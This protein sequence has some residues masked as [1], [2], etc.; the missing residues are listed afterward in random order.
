MTQHY[1]VILVTCCLQQTGAGICLWHK[2]RCGTPLVRPRAPSVHLLYSEPNGNISRGIV[3]RDTWSPRAA[4]MWWLSQAKCKRARHS[5]YMC[6]CGNQLQLFKKWDHLCK[7]VGHEGT[8][9]RKESFNLR[10]INNLFLFLFSQFT[11]FNWWNHFIFCLLL[12]HTS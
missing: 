8:D 4:H 11:I 6:Q 9:L 7:L 10:L 3:R 1:R 2:A 12:K 5:L